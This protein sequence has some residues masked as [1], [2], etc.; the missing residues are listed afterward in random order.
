MTHFLAVGFI[1]DSL[2]EIKQQA[3]ALST[4]VNMD[5]AQRQAYLRMRAAGNAPTTYQAALAS[6]V[7]DLEESLRQL[8]ATLEQFESDPV[9]YTGQGDTATV[10]AMLERLLANQ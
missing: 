2:H 10:L 5:E 6:G 8:V 7:R 9:V 1:R 4:L 3:E